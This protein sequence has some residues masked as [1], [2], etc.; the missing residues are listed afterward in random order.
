M[1]RT[2]FYLLP[3]IALILLI[4]E[5]K[6]AHELA[7]LGP[8][9]QKI[10]EKIDLFKS[11]NELLLTKVASATALTTVES[12]AYELGYLPPTSSQYLNWRPQ[13]FSV[14]W[15]AAR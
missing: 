2:I 8:T 13:E 9:V 14:V 7:Q 6:T 5:V 10:N 11:E 1:K 15:Q 4:W 12:R 3:L